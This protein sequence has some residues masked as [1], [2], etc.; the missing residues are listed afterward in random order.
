MKHAP[1]GRAGRPDPASSVAPVA[2]GYER[3][4]RPCLALAQHTR[5]ARVHPDLGSSKPEI[6]ESV[7]LVDEHEGEARHE[8]D[9]RRPPDA[10]APEAPA[11]LL[12]HREGEPGGEE[13]ER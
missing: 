1:P 8:P 6:D 5:S 3:S 13:E 9:G 2:S 10:P 7:R 12:R 4:L 11:P